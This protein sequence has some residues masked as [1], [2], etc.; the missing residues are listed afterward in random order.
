[1]KTVT[2]D[3]GGTAAA[4]D[5]TLTATGPTPICGRDRERRRDER[6]VSAGTYTLTETGPAGYTAWAWS[7]VGG[8]QT[9]S[10]IALALGQSATCTITNDDQ[11]RAADV[12]QDVVERQRRHRGRDR[13]DADGDRADADQRVRPE[14]MVTAAPVERRHLHAVGVGSGRLHGRRVVVRRR[15]ADRVIDHGRARPDGDLHD[16][17]RRHAAD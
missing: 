2:N 5:W 7:C 3:N 8:T 1:M 6:V 4:T 15:D 11:P 14:R 16:H 12:G 9:G 17:Q 10:S 13:L